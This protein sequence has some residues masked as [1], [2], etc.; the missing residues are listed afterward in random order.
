MVLQY[1]V[2][3]VSELSSA[4]TLPKGVSPGSVLS[5]ASVF[6]LPL[7]SPP[8][9]FPASAVTGLSIASVPPAENPAGGC[10]GGPD[11]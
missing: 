3:V 4:R 7:L 8:L 5:L 11:V 2:R 9:S 10:S 1:C 6:D